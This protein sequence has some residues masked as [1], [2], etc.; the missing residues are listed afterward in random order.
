MNFSYASEF[1]CKIWS[2]LLNRWCVAWFLG[3]KLVYQTTKKRASGPKCPV[4]GKRIQG[5]RILLFLFF[6]F[7]SNKLL[8][9]CR[10]RF[11]QLFWFRVIVL[12]ILLFYR[13]DHCP[14]VLCTT[15]FY[16]FWLVGLRYGQ[17]CSCCFCISFYC[18]ETH[19]LYFDRIM[20]LNF[21]TG[22]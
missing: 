5:V 10:I 15:L 20:R 21:R 17:H 6:L 8:Q 14:Y 3:G 13:L 18:L 11:W 19:G 7:S 12:G 22:T 2:H 9:S 4:T 1:V 16:K